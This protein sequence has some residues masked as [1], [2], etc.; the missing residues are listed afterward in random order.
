MEK[1]PEVFQIGC[2]GY[3]YP[4]WKN[5]FY[6][7]KLAPKNW[8]EY[9]SSVFN[10]VELNGTFYRTPKLADLQKYANSTPADF[11]FSVK[12][13]KYI[14]HILRLKESKQSILDFIALAEEG[15][16]DKLSNLLF[17]LPPT[18][19]YTEANLERILENIPHSAHHIVELRH[20]SWWSGAVEKAFRDAGLCF[21]N[22]DFPGMETYFIQT[23]PVFYLRL[24]GNP[25][26]FKSSYSKE[27]LE[28]FYRQIPGGCTQ[29]N[30]YFNNTFFEAGYQNAL[31]FMEIAG[32]KK[33]EIFPHQSQDITRDLFSSL[34]DPL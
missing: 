25:V 31:E 17:Q 27:S 5:K 21:C 2:S 9:Y 32:I 20:P 13:S 30:V 15:L 23:S 29:Y 12:V 28:S 33:R 10:T 11:K 18:F 8:L 6:P 26:L 22:V 34:P 14:T 1:T 3:Y 24:H 19:Q 16:G 4:A 7:H